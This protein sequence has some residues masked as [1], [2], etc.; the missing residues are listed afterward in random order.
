L[1]EQQDSTRLEEELRFVKIIAIIAALL[2]LWPVLYGLLVSPPGAVSL[3]MPIN[4]DDHMVYAAWMRQA[5]D[6]RIFMDNRFAVDSQP[7]L[8]VHFY[9][10][11]LGWLAKLIG[12]PSAMHLA[13]LGFA[14]LF[15]FLAY[16]LIRRTNP[17][18]FGTKLA[19]SL[20]LMGGG[21]GFLM[22]HNFGLA[23]VRPETQWLSPLTG[24]RLP[25]DVWQPEAFVAP[26]VLTS[27]LFMVSLCLMVWGFTCIL[28]AKDGWKSVGKGALAFFLLMNIHS[29][30][31]LLM[32]LALIGFLVMQFG[33]GRADVGWIAR[34]AVIGCGA[35]PS[36]LWFLHVLRNDPVFQARAATETYSG[37]FRPWLIAF[38]LL[39]PFGLYAIASAKPLNLRRALGVTG[40]LFVFFGL[41]A[42]GGSHDGGYFLDAPR[43]AICFGL[44]LCSLWALATEND[45]LNLISS[46][47]VIGVIAPYFP[48]LFQRKL[49]MGLSVPW[50]ILTALGLAALMV[51]RERSLRNLI[52]VFILVVCSATSIRWMFRE[53]RLLETNLSSTTVHAAYISR[54]L[55]AAIDY[56]NKERSGVR[57]VVLAMPGVARPVVDST[58]TPFPDAY[59]PPFIPDWNPFLS[60]LA[61]VYSYAGH[62]SETPD[63][64]KRRNLATKFFLAKT[65]SEERRAILDEVKPDF[66]LAP[67]AETFGEEF[68]SVENLGTVVIRGSQFCLIKVAH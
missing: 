23:L 41:Y 34:A 15:I 36:A 59:F 20:T 18:I 26:S 22:W 24:G 1:A 52:T 50:A 60:G 6:G 33:A 54:D 67:E 45:A 65:S 48:A 4:T 3:G 5:M 53:K 39:I 62:W 56:L 63:Y 49:S 43:F 25:N 17:T 37:N 32:A 30:D 14:G 13:R 12:I 2:A 9:F 64:G 27:G 11:A 40:V 7:G 46:W 35:I 57:T 19:V 66:L 8:T 58:G 21:I 31:V 61:G 29:Y 68:A 55:A 44:L 47:A 42:A 10:L 28:E 16:R 51:N 38:C